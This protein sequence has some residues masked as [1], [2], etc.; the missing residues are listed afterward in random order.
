MSTLDIVLLLLLLPFADAEPWPLCGNGG[1]YTANSSYQSNLNQLSAVL[2]KKASSNR[3]LFATGTAGTTPDEVYALALC[4]GDINA[5]ACNDCV[6]AGFQDAQ[7]L[8]PFS[9]EATMYYDVCLLSFSS[10][11]FLSTTSS[12]DSGDILLIWNSQNFTESSASISL[13]LF[14]LLNDTALSA[15]N[16]SRRFTTA[17]MDISSLPTMY[18]VVQC[19]PDLTAGECAACLQDFPQLTLMYLDGRRGGRVLRVRCNMRYE[20]YPFYQGD[21]MLRIISLATAVPA[22]NNTPPGAPVT[23]FPQPPPA[24]PPPAAI[25]PAGPAQEHKGT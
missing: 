9:K 10:I 14:T 13:L 5:S 20:I 7:Q 1:N 16:S 18:C 2:P 6:A 24:V 8:C 12:N 15:V 19:T 11:D 23:V 3:N 17:R 25:I 22:I 4:R 21:P